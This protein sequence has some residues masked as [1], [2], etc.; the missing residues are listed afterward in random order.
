MATDACILSA[1]MAIRQRFASSPCMTF[2]SMRVHHPYLLKSAA[3]LHA[4][5][6]VKWPGKRLWIN[7]VKNQSLTSVLARSAFRS[8]Y[9]FVCLSVCLSARVTQRLLLRLTLFIYAR[10]SISMARSSSKVIRSPIPKRLRNLLKDSS[11]SQDGT[12]YE[13]KV[14]DEI[15]RALC[16]KKCLITS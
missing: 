9:Q 7:I 16:W 6:F 14:R 11:P 4:G 10:R 12:N 13:I 5:L 15:K 8:V 1:K 2:S 3:V